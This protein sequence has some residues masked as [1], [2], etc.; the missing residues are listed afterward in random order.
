[1][2]LKAGIRQHALKCTSISELTDIKQQIGENDMTN[3][4]PFREMAQAM[5]ARTGFDGAILKFNKGNWI[6]G[7]DAI[8][9]NEAE[10]IA[11]VDRIM[12]GFVKWEDKRAVDFHVGFVADRFRPPKRPQLGDTDRSLWDK[13]SQ[14][15]WQ[16][17]FVLPMASA[18]DGE[19]YFFS[20]SSHGGR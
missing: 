7:K 19:L 8:N 4:D 1:M 9:M 14:D 13:P 6:A 5:R 3:S 17:T 20:T 16:L 15:P 10:L 11:L 2:W 18:E 12:Y